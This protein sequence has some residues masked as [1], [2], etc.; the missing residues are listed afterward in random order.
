M[1]VLEE[2]YKDS[3]NNSSIFTYSLS[4]KR[5]QT[6]HDCNWWE[7]DKGKK[8]IYEFIL[9]LNSVLKRLQVYFCLSYRKTRL[10]VR[11][12]RMMLLWWSTYRKCVT[13]LQLLAVEAI[14]A[15]TNLQYT[16]IHCACSDTKFKIPRPY[17]THSSED[18]L[19]YLLQ[20]RHCGIF[21]KLCRRWCS[22]RTRYWE[23]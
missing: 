21:S 17:G 7:S 5:R 13:L 6:S 3:L 19:L 15:N 16:N 20:F 23:N 18:F 2:A 12:R 4:I 1:S 8:R 22:L 9:R 11:S 10:N 14:V